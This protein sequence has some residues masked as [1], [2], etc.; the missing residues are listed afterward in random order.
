M[1]PTTICITVA[2]MFH[3]FF[4]FQARPRFS[5]SQSFIFTQWPVGIAKS[6]RWQFFS[7]NTFLIEDLSLK[8]VWGKSD[9]ACIEIEVKVK[10]D[11][12]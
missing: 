3:N 11:A 9:Q 6:T 5:I 4:S 8:P 10:P 2:F 1:T 12:D 7:N